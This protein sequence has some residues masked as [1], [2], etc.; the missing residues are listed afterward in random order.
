MLPSIINPDSLKDMIAHARTVPDG[1]FVEVGVYKGGSAWHLAQLSEQQDRSLYLFDTF[2]GIPYQDEIDPA[3]IGDFSDTTYEAVRAALPDA[4]ITVGIFPD[5]V[6]FELEPVAFVHLDVD[7]YKSYKDA[8]AY[9][10]P[11]MVPGGIMWFDDYCLPGAKKAIDEAF[12]DRV[13]TSPTN[14]NFVRF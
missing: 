12:G 4:F 1:C 8:I 7:Q 11:R 14:K 9:L 6:N 2:T 13:Q 5:S 3:K 10:S